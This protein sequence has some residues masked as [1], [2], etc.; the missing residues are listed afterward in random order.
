LTLLSIVQTAVEEIGETDPISY[1]A[2]N[3][4]DDAARQL[5]AF[6]NKVG[7]ELARQY[8]WQELL[9]EH[10]FSTVSG[11]ASY[12]LPADFDSMANDSAWDTTTKRRMIGN[13]NP[14]RWRALNALSVYTALN[15]NYR[16]AGSKLVLYPTPSSVIAMAFD[17]QSKNWCESSAGVGKTAFS[18]DTD[19][20]LISEDLIVLGVKY[21]FKAD[22]GMDAT[23]AKE[24]YQR[25]FSIIKN[26]NIPGGIIDMGEAVFRPNSGYVGNLP[27][28]I[29][30]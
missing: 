8:A 14:F 9:K 6:T 16:I 20:S 19:I 2:G 13:T 5:F 21:Y 26:A 22:N 3:T 11:T 23:T 30:V 1:V 27:D 15:F 18:A 10:T 17:Y 29:D 4:G 7:K 12:D 24:E 25:A 28:V